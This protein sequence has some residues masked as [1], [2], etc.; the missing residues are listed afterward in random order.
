MT[1]NNDTVI[2]SEFTLPGMAIWVWERE[3]EIRICS[4]LDK[5][6]NWTNKTFWKLFTHI[7]I[8]NWQNI[9]IWVDSTK[10]LQ[11]QTGRTV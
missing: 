4:W 10:N 6:K 3:R 9:Q 1:R 5:K 8:L 11:A 7:L 2:Y